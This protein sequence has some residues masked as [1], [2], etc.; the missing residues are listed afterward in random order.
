MRYLNKY[1]IK[2]WQVLKKYSYLH[3]T[4]YLNSLFFL[5][6]KIVKKKKKSQ[7]YHPRP[8]QDKIITGTNNHAD[9]Q[10]SDLN[11]F[12]IIDNYN[13]ISGIGFFEIVICSLENRCQGAQAMTCKTF[14]LKQENQ[15]RPRLQDTNTGPVLWWSIGLL[16]QKVNCSNIWPK[17]WSIS[18]SA[19]VLDHQT[20]QGL[21]C[22]SYESSHTWNKAL[23]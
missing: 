16:R 20:P 5:K 23:F 3:S 1:C 12:L 18:T 19:E 7:K 22:I 17:L 8:F 15:P 21:P 13:L 6:N 2:I 14:L 10:S 9:E 11:L 4:A